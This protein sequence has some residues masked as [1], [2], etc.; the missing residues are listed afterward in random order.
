MKKIYWLLALIIPWSCDSVK[1]EFKPGTDFTSYK[2]FCWLEGCTF[3]YTGP[4]Y[5]NKP[6]VQENIKN[7]IIENLTRKGLRYDNDT[8]DL[9]VD[10]HVTLE[11][12]VVIRYHSQ[13][14]EPYYYKTPFLRAD[15]IKVTHGTLVIHIIDRQRSELIW[16]SYVEGFMETPPDLSEKNIKAGIEKAMRDFPPKPDH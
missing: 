9:L 6:E 4:E 15:E 3:F 11:E 16:Q 7:A 13:E 1:T 12:E 14:D 8:P 10:F 5:L 2:S